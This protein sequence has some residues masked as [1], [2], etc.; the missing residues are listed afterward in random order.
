MLDLITDF[1]NYYFKENKTEFYDDN[2]LKSCLVYKFLC[3][4]IIF[5]IK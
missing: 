3:S 2:F 4:S 5:L 1:V